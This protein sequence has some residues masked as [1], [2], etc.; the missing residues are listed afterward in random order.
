MCKAK[1]IGGLFVES[2]KNWDS[3]N[4]AVEFVLGISLIFYCDNNMPRNMVN[5]TIWGRN[6]KV[7]IFSVTIYF[8]LYSEGSEACQ[9]PKLWNR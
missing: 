9:C 5:K 3:L 1:L 6:L 4:S 2:R 7:S 8:L